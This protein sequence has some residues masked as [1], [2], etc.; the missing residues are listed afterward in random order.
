MCFKPTV[1][2]LNNL[3]RG[4]TGIIA[5]L[6]DLRWVNRVMQI[7]EEW[8]ASDVVQICMRLFRVI[9]KYTLCHDSLL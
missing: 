5:F 7:A 3:T 9:S 4:D 8:A 6:K 1:R 2:L